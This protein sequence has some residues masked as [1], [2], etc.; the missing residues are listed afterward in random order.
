[1]RCIGWC[2]LCYEGAK[3]RRGHK[4]H[5]GYRPPPPTFKEDLAMA[6]RKRDKQLSAEGGGSVP[7]IASL[8]KKYPMLW[9]FMS[10]TRYDDGSPRVLPTV[11]LFVT[12]EGLKASLNDRDQGQVAFVT[13]D[14]LEAVLASLEAGLDGDTLDWRESAYGKKK[15]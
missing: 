4:G 14:S 2:G 3:G 11:S 5:F 7:V 8:A 10:M 9:E 6:L 1:M 13:G 15:K 12:A